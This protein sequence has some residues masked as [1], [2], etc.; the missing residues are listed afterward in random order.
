MW[1]SEQFRPGDYPHGLHDFG[2]FLSEH[3][4]RFP[5]DPYWIDLP[6]RGG[7][8]LRSRDDPEVVGA[9]MGLADR[10]GRAYEVEFL[11]EHGNVTFSGR[12]NA[13]M[14]H[15]AVF[16]IWEKRYMERRAKQSRFSA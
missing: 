5:D 10:D 9:I 8:I 6:L 4:L 7:Q 11:D 15:L 2:T 16:P 14:F 3:D 13:D 1:E 12:M